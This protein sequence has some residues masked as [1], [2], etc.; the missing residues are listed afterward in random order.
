MATKKKKTKT[1]KP[2]TKKKVPAKKIKVPSKKKKAAKVVP[3]PHAGKR[4]FMLD[5]GGY[6][7]EIMVDNV[8]EEFVQ[9]WLDE[10]RKDLLSGHILAM[11]EKAA[12]GEDFGEEVEDE[13]ESDDESEFDSN[14]PEVVPG[15]KYVEYWELDGIEHDTVVSAEYSSFTVTEVELHPKAVYQDG[16]VD[17]DDK[18][19]KKRNFDW[20]Q[21]RYTEKG[22]SK[23]FNTE[24]IKQVYCTEMFVHDTKKGLVD[25]VPV[26][27][28]YD[29]QKGSFGRVVVETNGQDFD[30]N[31]LVFGVCENT[32]TTH[33]DQYFYD[34]KPLTVD[35]DYLSTW[36]KG[37]H[38]SVGYMPK[39]DTEYNYEEL[40]KY[41]WEELEETESF[42][43]DGF[44]K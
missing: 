7:G 14:S 12:Y 17:W 44:G 37:F 16:A 6:G 1:T 43:T 8:S 33:I 3:N 32:M 22:E 36:G 10:D 2:S 20:S 35:M 34:K 15:R 18:E 29:A 24:G 30:V 11:H 5:F 4:Y 42:D 40:L 25:P 19:T 39:A 41:G 28:C 26:L 23:D 38:T 31:K 21:N 27:M 9:Y 13:D